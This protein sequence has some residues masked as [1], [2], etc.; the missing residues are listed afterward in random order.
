MQSSD[1]Y[2]SLDGG[3]GAEHGASQSEHERYH[4]WPVACIQS[5]RAAISTILDERLLQRGRE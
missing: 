1:S 4:M 2:G 3:R 5:G